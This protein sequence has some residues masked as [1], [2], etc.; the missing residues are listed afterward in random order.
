M[1][2]LTAFLL[3]VVL[4]GALLATGFASGWKVENW[5][6]SKLRLEE[7]Q[8]IQ[9]ER[10][11]LL[12]RYNSKSQAFEILRHT[13]ASEQRK[14]NAVVRE[15]IERPVYRTDCIDDDGL[16]QLNNAIHGRAAAASEPSSA[17]PVNRRTG[18]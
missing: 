1:S 2:S 5:R 9:K 16:R 8:R 4:A 13:L 7:V 12:K 10:D 11:E 6:Q 15:I 17:V 14:T 18:G 3:Q